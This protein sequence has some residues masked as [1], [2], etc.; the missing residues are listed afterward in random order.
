MSKVF[1]AMSIALLM[2]P[3]LAIQQSNSDA[4]T[5]LGTIIVL[6]ISKDKAYLAAD[7]RVG[8]DNGQ[9][10]DHGCKVIQV[11]P[12]MLFAAAGRVAFGPHSSRFSAEDEAYAAVRDDMSSD[13]G[14][15]MNEPML[16]V[17]ENWGVKVAMQFQTAYSNGLTA[18]ASNGRFVPIVQGV[19]VSVDDSKGVKRAEAPV[20]YDPP[21]PGFTGMLFKSQSETEEVPEGVRIHAYG[22]AGIVEEFAN[23]ST[24]RAREDRA[25][26]IGKKRDLFSS[27][28]AIH[29]VEKTIQ[30]NL[31]RSVVG[32]PIDVAEI[33]PTNGV[34]W[35]RRKDE[36]RQP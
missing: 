35:I 9:F 33:T 34:H 13:L 36:C 8:H 18:L 16:I 24:P 27:E 31:G 5:D 19:F 6:V 2:T 21:D 10:D 1:I 11:T 26:W 12:K 29:L 15:L 23:L 14:T 17:A 22:Q 32:G 25:M 20:Y 28:Y 3:D 30:L 7:S 4:H